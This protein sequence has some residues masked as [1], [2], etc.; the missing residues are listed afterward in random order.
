MIRGDYH[1]K[2]CKNIWIF[3]QMLDSVLSLP[4]NE[5]KYFG[6]S[7]EMAAWSHGGMVALKD[8]E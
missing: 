1:I 8:E 7:N 5:A 3:Q 2:F 6:F 4:N